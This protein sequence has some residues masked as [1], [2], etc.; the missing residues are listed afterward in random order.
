MT[1]QGRGPRVPLTGES[2]PMWQGGRHKH[3]G[4]YVL[5]YCPGHP[6]QCKL[7]FVFEHRLV[8]EKHLG[9]Y[10]KSEEIIHHVNGDPSDNR[11]ENLEVLSHGDHMR[12]HSDCLRGRMK[13]K[14]KESYLRHLYDDCELSM[15]HIGDV[16]GIPRHTIGNYL[17]RF[18][19]K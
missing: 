7:N 19:L 6:N 1:Y 2:H 12:R 16:T 10:L 9:R 14:I 4:G 18:G 11:I 13:Y 5:A 8:M 3:S 15:V 17:K